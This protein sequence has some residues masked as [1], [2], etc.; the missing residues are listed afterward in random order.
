VRELGI[1]VKPASLF[2]QARILPRICKLQLSGFGGRG[3][4]RGNLRLDHGLGLFGPL[5]LFAHGAVGP[6]MVVRLIAAT[7]KAYSQRYSLTTQ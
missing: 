1:V 3:L 5:M 6:L 7:N 2:L 4:G